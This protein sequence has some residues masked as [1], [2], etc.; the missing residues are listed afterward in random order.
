MSLREMIGHP[1]PPISKLPLWRKVL[2][3]CGIGF[4]VFVGVNL[5][6]LDLTIYGW[7]PDHAVPATGQVY[8]VS[9]NHGYLRYVTL[10]QFQ[11]FDLARI[12]IT[13]GG[14]AFVVAFFLMVTSHTLPPKS[15]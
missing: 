14:A 9:V 15:R 5:T 10:Q 13:W 7:A 12:A 2:I 1:L 11:N 4:F 6:Y 8:P 3:F